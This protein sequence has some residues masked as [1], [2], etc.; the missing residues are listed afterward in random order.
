MSSEKDHLDE[1][2]LLPDNQKFACIS[3][4]VPEDKEIKKYGLKLRG[5]FATYEEACDHAKTLQKVDKYHNVFVGEM[6]K[7][8]PF[9]PDPD[10]AKESE[11][12]NKDLDINLSSA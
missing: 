5:C 4:F 1:D 10:D 9:S 2:L 11:Y 3:F 8:L 7:W 12:S 6:G